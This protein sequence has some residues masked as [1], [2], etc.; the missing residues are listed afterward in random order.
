MIK[1][2]SLFSG[3]GGMDLGFIQTGLFKILL[4]NDFDKSACETYRL[5][6]GD[7]IVHDDIRN[8]NPI[9]EA[10]LIIGGPPC[11]GFSLANPNRALD[12]PRNWLFKE[13]VRI[14]KQVKPKVFLMENV[15]GLVTLENGK[16]FATIKKEFAR[17][18][19]VIN[20]QLLNAVNYEVPQNRNRII[21]VG[22]RDDITTKYSFPE[23]V[24]NP[25]IWGKYKTVGET[26]LNIK[27][28]PN[29]PNHQI[30]KLTNLNLAR[31][32]QIPQ[33]GSMRHCESKLQNNSDLNRAMRR[34]DAKKQSYTI[35]H[36]NCD[37]YYH[38]L[39]NRR[40]TIRE[41]A[42]LQTY[43]KDYIF[44]GGKSNQSKQVGNSVP[45]RLGY[46]LAMSIASFLSQ[47]TNKKLDKVV[48][49]H[50]DYGIYRGATQ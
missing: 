23:P 28:K 42:L 41:M 18:G 17:C 22:I 38:P 7:H 13:Y 48:V 9:V 6:I 11:Q 14:L 20:E 40:L 50:N 35:V 29:D 31:I 4:A 2:I 16:I 12:D 26:I 27:L 8:L 30:G 45:V 46:H 5:N 3:S 37:H 25:P 33:G 36:N 10:D 24:L 34:L 47:V 19:Y 43:P 39:E 32:K 15:S 44:C 1:T 49:T 21:L